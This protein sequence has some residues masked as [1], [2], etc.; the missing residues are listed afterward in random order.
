MKA[1]AVIVGGGV[2]GLAVAYELGL[3]GRRDVVVVERG[4]LNGGATGRCGGGVRQQWSTAGNITLMKRA[5]E[6]YRGL[7]SQTGENVWF[8]QDGYLFLAKTAEQETQLEAGVK[9]Q[10]EH[11]VRSRLLTRTEIR[12]LCPELNIEGVRVGAYNA[13]DGTLFPFSVS[14]A[15]AKGIAKHGNRILLHTDVTGIDGRDGRIER[16]H[17]SA[18]YIETECVVNCAGAWS[19]SIGNMLGV[20]L[21]NHPEKH[22]AIVTEAL[23][24]FLK[25][26]LVPMDSGLFVSQTMRGEIYACVGVDK[27]PATSYMPTFAFMRKISRLMVEL[28]PRLA[29]VKVLRHWGGFYDI[30]PDTNPILGPVR[31]WDGFIQCHGFMGH[32]F[33]MAPVIAELTAEYLVSGVRHPELDACR[34]E[35]FEAGGLETERMIIG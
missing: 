1:S 15:Y 35:R 6:L 31:G 24:P 3:R 19:P 23:R 32:G 17:T 5:V 12:S 9:L 33:M 25:P 18:G 30:T 28:V 29:S 21:P 22:E 14:W 27:A 10:N 7:A 8:R 2:M 13:D 16:V 34:L 26:N 11:G 4:H 20:T